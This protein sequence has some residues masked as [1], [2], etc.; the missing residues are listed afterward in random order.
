MSGNSSR[1]QKHEVSYIE[2]TDSMKIVK[3]KSLEKD[4]TDYEFSK[5]CF[6]FRGQTGM[7]YEDEFCVYYDD[8]N[9]FLDGLSVMD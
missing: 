4:L 5:F 9:R 3:L 1:N 2:T 7:I 8:V 6:W